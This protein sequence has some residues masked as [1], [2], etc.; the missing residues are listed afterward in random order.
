MLT[1]NDAA[2]AER[3][4]VLSLHGI[5]A[6]AWKRYSREGSWFYEVLWP[7]YK[8]NMT[9]I[10]ASLGL[11]QLARLE[12]FI[13]RRTS[14]A[15]RYTDALAGVPEV[16]TPVARAGTRHAWHLYP[17]RLDL[18]RLTI[19]RSR[20]I[21]LLAERG[22]GA[23]VHFIPVH[24]HPYYRETFGCQRGDLPITERI[25]DG[26]VSLPLFPLM[27]DSDVDRVV[28]AVGSIVAASRA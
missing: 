5:S 11:H 8:Y 23:S 15:A 3:V 28:E 1:T 24:L 19:D 22:I 14:L 12:E 20:F 18:E 26:F 17:V 2:V 6:D 4:R 10:Q 27:S 7:G 21:A 25:Y 16:R 9:D 13:D